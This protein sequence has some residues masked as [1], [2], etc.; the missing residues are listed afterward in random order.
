MQNIKNISNQPVYH[1]VDILLKGFQSPSEFIKFITDAMHSVYLMD[2]NKPA[3]PFELETHYTLVLLL[4]GISEP[5]IKGGE[6]MKNYLVK[7]MCELL[8]AFSA[9]TFY[10]NIIH[11]SEAM[12]SDLLNYGVMEEDELD[13]HFAQI[14]AL[15]AVAIKLELYEKSEKL[16]TKQL[17]D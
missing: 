1:A 12:T 3:S 14:K 16:R 13:K 6:N 11:A 2:K 7:G 10:H 9:D 5:W 4:R 15:Y 17:T 8:D